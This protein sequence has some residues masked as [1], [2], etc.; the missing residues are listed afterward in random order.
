MDRASW[1]SSR[2]LALVILWFLFTCTV[3]AIHIPSNVK[4]LNS[5][6]SQ[7]QKRDDKVKLRILPLGASLTWGYLSDTGNG[8]RKPLRD[9]LRYDGYEVDMVGSK[10]NGNMK[11]NDVE[12][13]TGDV[14]TKIQEAGQN[15]LSYKP[16]V[17]LINA[18]TNDC[19]KNDVK[20]VGDRIHDLIKSLRKGDDM[21]DALIVM[22]TLLPSN[23]KDTAKN[24]PEANRQYRKLVKDLSDDGENILLADMDPESP[25]P[26]HNWIKYPN[27]YKHSDGT[28]DDTH[29]NDYGY[30][31]MAAVWYKTI[32]KAVSKDMIKDPVET[33]GGGSCEKDYGSGSSAGGLT[34]DGSG[35]DDGTYYHDSESRRTILEVDSPASKDFIF[36]RLFSRDRDDLLN[37]EEKEDNIIFHVWK[38]T[39]DGEKP[40]KSIDHAAVNIFCNPAGV[41]FVDVNGDGLDDYVCLGKE[42]N[43]YVDINQG[44]GKGDSPPSFKE[45]GKIKDSEYSQNKVRLADMDGDGRVDYCGVEGDGDI[46]CWRNGGTGDKPEYW[47]SLGKVFN[48]ED[49]G[50]ING[51]RFEDL[52]GDGRDDWLWLDDEGETTTWTNSRSCNKTDEGDNFNIIWRRGYQD[53]QDSG[54]THNG[55]GE[56]DGERSEVHFARVY[57]EPQNFGLLGRQDYVWIENTD[58]GVSVHVWKSKGYGA[59]KIK[60]TSD[61]DMYLSKQPGAFLADFLS[62][63]CSAD[64]NRYC[65]MMGHTN[66]LMDYVWIRSR[67]EMRLYPNKGETK[68]SKGDSFWGPNKIIWDPLNEA[69]HKKL[70]RR[71]L[72]L[73]DWD[74]DGACD[75]IWTD[76]DDKNRVKLWRNKIKTAKAD[77]DF[78]WEYDDNPASD[79]SCDEKR[80]V[81]PFDTPVRF[82]DITGNGKG[83]YLCM[84]KDGSTSGYVHKDDDS[85]EHVTQFKYS[86]DKDRANLQW[87]DV[88]GDGKADLV[89][90][91]KFNGDGSIWYNKGAKEVKG[92]SYEWDGVGVKF[93]GASAG[94]CT[95][96]PDL[97][98]DG[99]ADMHSI[100]HSLDNTAETWFNTCKHSNRKGDDGSIKDPKLPVMPT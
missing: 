73:V 53:G 90:T 22:S 21:K 5:S 92:S 13:H 7:F 19:R 43:A 48:G 37:W 87:A 72:H 70:D 18:G 26:G 41:R 33:K 50:D 6:G 59:A 42:G 10:N 11:D 77:D 40:Y 96:F 27:D 76:P 66:G 99:R 100:K 88:N 63:Y 83:D 55:V 28:T 82:A 32:K 4:S 14:I 57:G 24:Q 65:N 35:D 1:I 25:D 64:G 56:K 95:Y 39:G 47:Q 84:A 91:D 89:H 16:N 46:Y 38:N 97:D 62:V 29:P 30:S 58:D 9:Q 71:D 52:N 54:P 34:Q 51:V 49:M 36:A 93:Q 79:L 67:G 86:E 74:G 44:D 75:I 98:G 81:D 69:I 85:W 2:P 45:I 80:G 3:N 31:K 20:G 17:V 12:A 68:V 23:D 15:S 60:G 8:Y 78:K 94:S 61:M